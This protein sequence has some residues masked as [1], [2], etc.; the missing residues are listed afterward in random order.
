MAW[1]SLVGSGY[2][3]S[4]ILRK[5]TLFPRT[6][7]AS[8]SANAAYVKA[9]DGRT[10]PVAAHSP[11]GVAGCLPVFFS[12]SAALRRSTMSAMHK[13]EMRRAASAGVFAEEPMFIS[14]N[15]GGRLLD[16]RFEHSNLLWP[17]SGFL[18]LYVRVSP[19]G[20]AFK[21]QYFTPLVFQEP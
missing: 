3:F 18:A 20:A 6:V 9:L 14:T 19:E 10:G 11:V 2:I 17:W 13:R 12:S 21:V 4:T 1:A 5:P 7:M 8:T 15:E 16:V